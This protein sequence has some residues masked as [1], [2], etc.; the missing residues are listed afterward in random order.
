MFIFQ[1]TCNNWFHSSYRICCREEIKLRLLHISRNKFF[2][3]IHHSFILLLLLYNLL[4]F[5]SSPSITIVNQCNQIIKNN[6]EIDEEN[7]SPKEIILSDAYKPSNFYSHSPQINPPD[8]KVV[9]IETITSYNVSSP[10]YIDN[11]THFA[12]K[13]NSSGW[14]GDGSLSSPYIISNLNITPSYNL[15]EIL[16]TNVYF[17]IEKCL[18]IKGNIGIRLANVSN[19]EISENQLGNYYY[20]GIELV[21]SLE[22]NISSNKI[23]SEIGDHGIYSAN[24][25]NSII[26]NNSVFE[27]EKDG[28]YFTK[29]YNNLFRENRIYKNGEEGVTVLN[30]V[31]NIFVENWVFNNTWE[32]IELIR[33]KNC[34][35]SNNT[36]IKNGEDAIKLSFSND[37]SIINNTLDAVTFS[38]SFNPKIV[39]NNIF[40]KISLQDGG[41]ANISDNCITSPESYAIYLYEFGQNYI[42]NNYIYNSEGGIR[43]HSNCGNSSFTDLYIINCTNYGGINLA[44]CGN[45]TLSNVTVINCPSGLRLSYSENCTLDQF[46]LANFYGGGCDISYSSYSNITNFY[47]INTSSN[48]FRLEYT[49]LSHIRN[50]TIIDS[51]SFGFKVYKANNCFLFNIQ[52]INTTYTG[53][54][55]DY[56]RFNYISEVNITNAEYGLDLYS[57]NQSIFEKV[58]VNNCS[59]DGVQIDSSSDLSFTNCESKNG[60]LNGFVIEH[61][62]NLNFSSCFSH[63]NSNY[64][65]EIEYS[66]YCVFFKNFVFN[67]YQYGINI[68]K[69]IFIEVI[70]SNIYDNNYIGIRMYQSEHCSIIYSI[71]FRNKYVGL[72]IEKEWEVE[73]TGNNTI[74]RNDFIANNWGEDSFLQSQMQCGISSEKVSYNFWDSHREPDDDSDGIVDIPYLIGENYELEENY[75]DNYPLSMPYNV[76]TIHYVTQP[77]MI[78]PSS[79]NISEPYYIEPVQVSGAITVK[80]LHSIDSFDEDLKYSLWI[81]L[82]SWQTEENWTIAAEEITSN[83]YDW[84]TTSIYKGDYY[85]KVVASHI[86]GIN[87]SSRMQEIYINN[88]PPELTDFYS[89]PGWTFLPILWFMVIIVFYHKY[90]NHNK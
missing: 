60:Q 21:D 78:Y 67:N 27:N 50:I 63:S 20:A 5:S 49:N 69:S 30:S 70:Q 32:G 43:L 72:E 87:V 89:A 59:N 40:G 68:V 74:T 1:E 31:D 13:A 76:A 57:N 81:R 47:I 86:D 15:I 14:I 2:K 66:S 46:Y 8:C 51:H 42:S 19:G 38:D 53:F 41:Y 90:G 56:S 75:Y 85:I 11:N 28:L 33:S 25:N 23:N 48:G 24:T 26:Y 35:I 52:V 39:R 64:G 18:L 10:I 37:S 22:I 45:S 79:F 84:D 88:A 16:N 80:W 7:L 6:I 54:V 44:S 62:D 77:I 3:S 36:C 83:S 34:S 71:L 61:S 73:Y 17:K 4:V 12:D 55:I 82:R 58:I 65:I 29:S 9:N